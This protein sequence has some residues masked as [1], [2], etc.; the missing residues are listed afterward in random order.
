M[1]RTVLMVLRVVLALAG[2]GLIVALVAHFWLGQ[3]VMPAD[4]AAGRPEPVRLTVVA[5]N[6]EPGDRV[7][8]FDE[9]RTGFNKI[10][11]RDFGPGDD[12][13]TRV[14]GIPE[15]FGQANRGLL[16]LAL[17]LG[18]CAYPLQSWRWYLLMRSQ[19]MEVRFL[20]AFR[21]TLVGQFFSLALPGATGGD[22]I[23]AYYAAKGSGART[24]AITS[25][26]V[27]RVSGMTGLVLLVALLGLASLDEPMVRTLV[28][29]AWAGL[30]L[31]LAGWLAYSS[32]RLRSAVRMDTLVDRL[33]GQAMLRKLD[34]AVVAYRGQTGAIAAAIG[35]SLATHLGMASAVACVGFALGIEVPYLQLVAVLPAVFLIGTVPLVPS[36]LGVMEGAAAL[37][38]AAPTALVIGMMLGL[39]IIVFVFAAAGGIETIRGDIH[40]HPP[41]EPE[42]A[43]P[44]A[45][46]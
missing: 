32:K 45:E 37:L 17:V 18:F 4:P 25:V 46:A 5:I 30:V 31:L 14:P 35:L 39:R 23:K 24:R 33:P 41:V 27:D 22:L 36:G 9:Q 15:M 8:Y 40:L 42:D 21:L 29:I 11:E 44:Q 26:V 28:V 12:T 6:G 20:R 43:P 3:V 10:H 13:P 34:D 2:L 38:I 1:K 16:L 19:D 7:F